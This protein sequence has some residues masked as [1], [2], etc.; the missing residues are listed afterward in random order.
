MQI[1]QQE[2]RNCMKCCN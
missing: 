1:V 2:F